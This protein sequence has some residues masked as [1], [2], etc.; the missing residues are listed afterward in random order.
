MD[1][2]HSSAASPSPLF[3]VVAVALIHRVRP[4]WLAIGVTDAAK[5]EA[6]NPS[7][8]AVWR[9][10]SWACGNR[11]WTLLAIGDARHLSPIRMTSWVG[12]KRYS[13]WQPP[14]SPR[15]TFGAGRYARSWLEPGFGCIPSCRNSPKRDSVK[16]WHYQ[17]G[18]CAHGCNTLR[19]RLRPCPSQNKR[20]LPAVHASAAP[21]PANPDGHDSASTSSCPIRN[22]D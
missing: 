18:L 2:S 7:G 11:P 14:C 5:A 6:L 12:F 21:N 9:R 13:R 17:R 3:A 19:V 22:L 16:P 10:G 15:S 20:R 4:D 1:L 8:S